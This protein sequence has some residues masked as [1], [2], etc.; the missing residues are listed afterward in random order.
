MRT[1]I[2]RHAARFQVLADDSEP[3]SDDDRVDITRQAGR[4]VP[5]RVGWFNAKER[6]HW[7]LPHG[8]I[9]AAPGH[10]ATT[11]ARA[12]NA[13]GC[14]HTDKDGRLTRRVSVEGS[15]PR[16]YAITSVLLVEES[17]GEAAV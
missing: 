5:D 17:I 1:F 11:I 8:L 15:R 10:D 13:S 6:E 2:H 16:V 3:L 12:L 7:L 4:V 14:L 9:E